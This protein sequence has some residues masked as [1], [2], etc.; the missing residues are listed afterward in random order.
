MSQLFGAHIIHIFTKED[1]DLPETES[2]QCVLGG[3]RPARTYLDQLLFFSKLIYW[4][5]SSSLSLSP[6][7]HLTT[8]QRKLSLAA[9]F[10]C[11]V[12]SL[13]TKGEARPKVRLDQRWGSTKGEGEMT[14]YLRASSFGLADQQSARRRKRCNMLFCFSFLAQFVTQ[15]SWMINVLHVSYL[16]L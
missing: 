15:M 9:W 12:P 2:L 10:H 14:G 16:N 3:P 13:T 5:L 4:Y 1:S 6:T 7:V 11:L 8:L